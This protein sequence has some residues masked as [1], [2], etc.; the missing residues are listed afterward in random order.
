[1]KFTSKLLYIL[2][3]Q[4]LSFSNPHLQKIWSKMRYSTTKN[5]KC[6][7]QHMSN[8]ITNCES[9]IYKDPPAPLEGATRLRGIMCNPVS[10]V[11]CILCT[12]FS[13]S[14]FPVSVSGSLE[15][16]F[17]DPGIV[18]LSAREAPIYHQPGVWSGSGVT[19][20]SPWKVINF[21]ASLQGNKSHENLSQGHPKSWKIDPGIIRNP[22]SAKDDFCN[23]SLAK[24]LFL[25]S[26]TPKFKPKNH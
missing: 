26:Q 22:I 8:N 25:Q 9:H 11:P 17:R 19:P 7:L 20:E 2:L 1:M 4:S 6:C 10:S 14:R 21:Q 12:L 18:L 23:T 16:G 24:C 5:C 3:M 15:S 13:V